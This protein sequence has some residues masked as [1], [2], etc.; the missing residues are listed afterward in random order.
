MRVMVAAGGSGGHVYPALAVMEE[1]RRRGDLTQVV[2]VGNPKG[3]E[4]EILAKHSW[5]SFLPL[6]GQGL[7]RR[8]PW[9]WPGALVGAVGAVV[10]AMKAVRAFRPHVVLGMGGYP[11]F[12]PAVAAAMLRV[13]VVVHE[14]NACLGLVNRVLSKLSDEVLVSFPGTQGVR[15]QRAKTTGNPVREEIVAVGR[16][17][18]LGK[19]LLVFGGSQGSKV[20]VDAALEAAPKLAQLPGLR[21]RVVVGR[22]SEGAEVRR[23]LQD[24]G[25]DNVDIVDYEQD[26]AR[27]LNRA[28]LVVA[29][30]GA[31]TVAELAA[32]GRPAILVPWSRAAAGHQT[33]NARALAQRRAGVMLTDEELSRT[34][35]GA[36]VT[37][38]WEDPAELE[39]MAAAA[40]TAA[41]P[42][43]ARRVADA[44]VRVGGRS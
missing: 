4:A 29:R 12:A 3:I 23:R 13:P 40:R 39:A 41:C 11:A 20:L 10:K 1:L 33:Y 6:T 5:V 36:L 44:L 7:P 31:T 37:R 26:M 14:Q 15:G 19:E 16:K 22:A 27:A 8:K 35:L 38:L 34:D 43:A 18:G 25:L 21:M 42:D 28:R 30:A 24:A 9:R 17:P 2:W 32:A